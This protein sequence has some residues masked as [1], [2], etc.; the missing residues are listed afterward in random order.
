MNKLKDY[1]LA[2]HLAIFKKVFGLVAVCLQFFRHSVC[3]IK[4]EKIWKNN[5]N[6]VYLT[7]RAFSTKSLHFYS[8]QSSERTEK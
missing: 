8:S 5:E 3:R 1:L 6:V 7:K 2:A 4:K